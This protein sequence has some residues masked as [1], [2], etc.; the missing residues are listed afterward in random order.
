MFCFLIYN[1]LIYE[2]T[3]FFFLQAINKEDE[4]HTELTAGMCTAGIVLS[5]LIIMALI[6]RHKR[7]LRRQYRQNY[8]LWQIENPVY[9][10]TTT[11][12]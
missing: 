12:V 8:K 7:K 1:I 11:K 6:I 9:R 5:F 3:F 4:D 2:Y 10:H